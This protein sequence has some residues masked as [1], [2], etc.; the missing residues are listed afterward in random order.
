MIYYLLFAIMSGYLEGYF[1]AAYP[2]VSQRW[3]HVALTILRVIVL[4]P[5]FWYVGWLE[6]VAV[7]LM[8][9][10]FHDGAYYQT[11]EHIRP[12]TYPNGWLDYSK[13]TGAIFSFQ[14]PARLILLLVGFTL[15]IICLTR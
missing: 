13:E 6:A 8:F 7:A 2:P 9:P 5:V 11:R 14:F 4:F 15:Y 10:I 3:S 12:G 1:W